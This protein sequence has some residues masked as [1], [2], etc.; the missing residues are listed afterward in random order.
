MRGER[1]PPR[2]GQQARVPEGGGLLRAATA[3]H[4]RKVLGLSGFT[5]P[6]ARGE[7]L[8][9]ARS[10]PCRRVYPV[11]DYS[12]LVVVDAGAAGLVALSALDDEAVSVDV[13]PSFALDLV[14]LFDSFFA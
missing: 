1:R 10:A 4:R 3:G 8:T 12:D 7:A 13:L 5:R 14:A 6:R 2:H 11:Q 9:L